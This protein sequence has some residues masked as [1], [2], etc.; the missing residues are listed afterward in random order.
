MDEWTYNVCCGLA[1]VAVIGTVLLLTVI[2]PIRQL[3][4]DAQDKAKRQ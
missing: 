1:Y 2:L 3:Q 4:A